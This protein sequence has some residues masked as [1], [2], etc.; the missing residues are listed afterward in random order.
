MLLNKIEDFSLVFT[1]V[2]THNILLSRNNIIVNNILYLYG[3][4]YG[5]STIS[6]LLILSSIT[7][8]AQVLFSV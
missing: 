3:Y 4:N 8:S 5:I 7:K 2:F 1:I 6:L